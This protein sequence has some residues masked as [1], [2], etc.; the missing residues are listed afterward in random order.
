MDILLI[1]T[2]YS[3]RFEEFLED[4]KKANI[5]SSNIKYLLMTHHHDDHAGFAA[6]LKEKTNCRL[7]THK[8]SVKGLSAGRIVS[9]G[10]P[11]NRRVQVTMALY[12][13]VKRRDF[14]FQPVN[15]NVGDTLLTGDDEKTLRQL[16]ID[17]KIICTPGHTSDSISLILANGDA[18]ASDACM[19]FLGFC[20]IHYR[21]IFLE[22]L[23]EV[24]RSW[25]KIV[26]NCAKT[27]YPA[28]GEPFT[29]GQLVHFGR[30]YAPDIFPTS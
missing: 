9:L 19:N 17:G 23:D 26:D 10:K 25:R 13:A 24:F 14:S 12:N 30:K 18:Y 15:I 20:G 27:I 11:V 7:I 16:G 2:S 4:L 5:D 8:D 21:P 3:S 6:K 22:D 29:V 28:H 1:D